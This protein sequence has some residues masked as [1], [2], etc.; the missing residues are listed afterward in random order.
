MSLPDAVA[1]PPTVA[2]GSPRP[3]QIWSPVIDTTLPEEQRTPAFVVW[4]TSYFKHGDLS[5]R[6]TDVLEYWIPARFR[7]PTIFNLSDDEYARA[8]CIPPGE[9]SEMLFMF[10]CEP[11]IQQ[12]YNKACYDKSI[13]DL[14]PGLDIWVLSGDV[15][16]PHGL[17][18]FWSME[19]DDAKHGGGFVKFGWVPGANHFV[20]LSCC[21]K[22]SAATYASFQVLLGRA[23]LHAEEV[24]GVRV[25]L[26]A[27]S[28][29]V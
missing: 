7:V 8:V 12:T 11:A 19:D 25:E 28:W 15:T 14:F 1:E 10:F 6:N 22:L 5:T 9:K 13:R 17:P 27:T 16:S 29:L 2:I 23:R 21:L 18:A 20:R 26:G 24:P 3:S 4:I